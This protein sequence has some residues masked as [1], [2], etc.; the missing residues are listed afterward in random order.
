MRSSDERQSMLRRDEN[1][2][3][4]HILP[5]HCL[6]ES[7]GGPNLSE[8]LDTRG[9]SIVQTHTRSRRNHRHVVFAGGLLL[10]ASMAAAAQVV[11]GSTRSQ[12]TGAAVPG[13]ILVLVDSTNETVARTL[14]DE[15][16]DF[17]LH[18][19]TAGRYRVRAIRIGFRPVTSEFFGVL[20]DTTISLRMVDVPFDLPAVTTRERT[21]CS[22]R[23]DSALALGALWEDVKAA[24]LATAITR[25]GAGLRFDLMDHTRVYDFATRELLDVGLTEAAVYETRSW[26]SITP[27]RLRRDGYVFENRDSTAFVA[28]DIETLLSDY[29]VSTHCFRIGTNTRA[30]SLIAVEFDPA[31]RARH[32]EVRGTLWVDRRTHE[33]RSLDFRYVNLELP[34]PGSDSVA[35]GHVGFVRLPVGAWIV[36][37][38]EVRVPVAH[39]ASEQGLPP[40]QRRAGAPVIL[41]H[42]HPVI[43]ELRVSGG[44][45]RD[46]FRDGAIVWSRRTRS[47]RVHVMS[48]DAGGDARSN[49][50]SEQA[51][52][53]LVG[54]QRPFALA[55]TSGSV[56]I[57]ELLPGAYL[58]EVATRELDVLGW[59]RARVRV[60]VDS[61][62]LSTADV[63]VESS[64]EAARAVCLDD[65]K[66]LNRETGVIVGSIQRGGEP[67]SG[68]LVTVSWIGDAAGAHSPG[69]IISRTIRSLA[70]DGRFLACGVPRNR[71]IEIRVA[72][73]EA[74]PTETRLS[75]DQVVGIVSVALKRE[76]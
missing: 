11:R 66:T 53:F 34:V 54:S 75:S 47:I 23:P 43:D 69:S 74:A 16:G 24:L 36:S 63:H 35:G 44:T 45:L 61:T 13:T 76:P 40:A 50:P 72:G 70:S 17:V 60:D 71:S 6:A 20:G 22:V 25:E 52:V 32:V 46:V 26:A 4:R 67:V 21:Q 29:F 7:S 33:L 57:D 56:T 28:P 39:V 18:A 42:R 19:R 41:I 55:D 14:A 15:H 1:I 2:Q 59:A 30:D 37:D 8:I 10:I 64:L 38:W 31:M 12:A 9:P 49:A 73:D 27:E 48:G 65:A 5:G 62:A 3:T 58:I 68:R 51:A